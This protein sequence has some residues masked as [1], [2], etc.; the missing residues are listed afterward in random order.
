VW[1]ESNEG[2][3]EMTLA[4]TYSD[5]KALDATRPVIDT[6]GG[7]HAETDIYDTHDYEQSG[8]VFAARYAPGEPLYDQFAGRQK[9]D[10]AKP[11]FVSEYGGIRWTDDETGWGYGEGPKTA[12]EFIERY[13]TLTTALLR[14]P[15]HMGFCYTQ[16]TDVEQEQNGLYTYDRRAKFDPEI[17]K[18]INT[19]TAA[20]EK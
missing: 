18:E 1:G 12:E 19:Q 4:M 7:L 20:V 3:R 9:Y 16:L 10:G 8:Q 6:S 17:I 13:R 11:V 5:T 15:G 14:N 2:L